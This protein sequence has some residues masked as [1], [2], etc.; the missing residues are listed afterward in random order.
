MLS[1]LLVL[2]ALHAIPG[3]AAA[4]DAASSSSSSS[5]SSSASSSSPSATPDEQ[6]AMNVS[7]ETLLASS[8][9][10]TVFFRQFNSGEI[11]PPLEPAASTKLPT[12]VELR[13]NEYGLR[14]RD[15]DGSLQR[16]VLWDAGFVLPPGSSSGSSTS[17]AT[18]PATAAPTPRPVSP[19]STPQPTASWTNSSPS[20]VKLYTKHGAEMSTI[21]LTRADMERVGCQLQLCNAGPE[22]GSVW[23]TVN[24]PGAAIQSVVRCA[25]DASDPS[26]VSRINA[27]S[28]SSDGRARSVWAGR[29]TDDKGA[30]ALSGGRA[31]EISSPAINIARHVW[32]RDSTAVDPATEEAGVPP[33]TNDGVVVVFTI[34]TVPF[35]EE[36]PVGQC[37]SQS[38]T[39]QGEVIPSLIIPCVPYDSRLAAMTASKGD[40]PLW[41]QPKTSKLMTAWLQSVAPKKSRI[42][43]G[44]SPGTNSDS[45]E[46]LPSP[47]NS[48]GSLRGSSFDLWKLIPI[49][50]GA[51]VATAVVM[52]FVVFRRGRSRSS[53]GRAASADELSHHSG[54]KSRKLP[55]EMDADDGA[56]MDTTGSMFPTRDGDVYVDGDGFLSPPSRLQ[57]PLVA[58]AGTH[59][60][61]SRREDIVPLEPPKPKAKQKPT[62]ASAAT[63][64]ITTATATGALGTT[65]IEPPAASG[66]SWRGLRRKSAQSAMLHA[67]YLRRTSSEPTSG[68]ALHCAASVDTEQ[69]RVLQTD[70]SLS[71]SRLT[72]D[73][74]VFDRVLSR[75]SAHEV[76]LCQYEGEEL[77]VKRLLPPTLRLPVD[78]ASVGENDRSMFDQFLA[79]IQLTASLD[80]PN[81]VRFVGV[82]WHQLPTESLCLAMEYEVHGDLRHYLQRHRDSLSW[83]NHKLAWAKGVTRGLSYLHQLSSSSSGERQRVLHMELHAS[84]VVLSDRLE[85]KLIDLGGPCGSHDEDWSQLRSSSAR[86]RLLFPYWVAPEVFSGEEPSTASDVYALGMLLVELDGAQVP[87]WNARNTSNGERLKPFQLVNMAVAG[88]LRPTFSTD[89]PATMQTLILECLRTKAADRP[90]LRDVL[91]QLNSMDQAMR[92]SGSAE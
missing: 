31:V 61:V 79:E 12:S 80:H 78:D 86:S 65:S 57:V 73:K 70:P 21:A 25:V 14:F 50:I 43:N 66:S 71:S 75:S 33:P 41:Q 24:C 26:V 81:V 83:K 18:A 44:P 46:I 7:A 52:G 9:L 89:C 4:Q 69:L 29:N 91:K 56:L 53:A 23:R 1:T 59:Q 49:V 45:S 36:P 55:F 90:S 68:G 62:T 47:Q 8:D 28:Q 22:L 76:W 11:I 51:V 39:E 64:G 82:A 27:A 17:G 37:P 85:P 60:L 34:H 10:T 48:G 5:S 72:F 6:P 74:L 77:A 54:S 40:A 16:A 63:A 20:F 58:S 35:R 92:R 42:V 19:G 87:F 88:R 84:H 2:L 15:L 67:P 38:T 3:A 32:T 13:L 30:T